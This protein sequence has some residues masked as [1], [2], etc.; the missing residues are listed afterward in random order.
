MGTT[1]RNALA[2]SGLA[3]VAALGLGACGPTISKAPAAP[4]SSAPAAFTPTAEP[5]AIPAT[6]AA[7]PDTTGP[8]GTSFTVT[9]TDDS[10]SP[11][12]YNVT[13]TQ[14]DQHA[15]LS[16]YETVS[17]PGDHMAAARF[18]VTGVTGQ[19]SDDANSDATAVG[20]DT[21]VYPFAATEVSDGPNFSS[22]MFQVGPG[23]TE[24]GWVAFEVPA[25]VTVASVAWQPGIDGPAATW[26]LGS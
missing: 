16:A 7:T 2:V 17:N 10:G 12:V 5:T 3:V 18:T 22:G 13:L 25:G 9:T 20:S 19:E 8:L 24:S 23:R 14:V 11:V 1:T 4:K 26:T 6:T 15:A 21:T